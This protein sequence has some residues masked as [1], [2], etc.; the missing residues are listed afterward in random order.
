MATLAQGGRISTDIVEEEIER[1]NASWTSL[2]AEA[3]QEILSRLLNRDQLTEID[4]FDRAQLPLELTPAMEA[5][6]DLLK[7]CSANV[8]QVN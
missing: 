1:M 5:T 4:L 6:L 2:E 7:T 3:S 8:Q